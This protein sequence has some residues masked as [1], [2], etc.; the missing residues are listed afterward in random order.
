MRVRVQQFNNAQFFIS[1]ILQPDCVW[2]RCAYRTMWLRAPPPSWNASTIWTAR[3]STRS[4]GTR[5]AMSFIAMC[6][7]I[8][9]RR[10]HF[11]CQV[12]PLMWVCHWKK[13]EKKISK[14][15]GDGQ[16]PT[17]RYL[18]PWRL[19]WLY[20]KQSVQKCV[21]IRFD[22]SITQDVLKI[23]ELKFRSDFSR[24]IANRKKL[25]IILN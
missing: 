8:I 4:N 20:I 23:W 18:R 22:D 21:Y 14:S 9:R 17:G 13:S 16:K 25:S 10:K 19:S 3:R 15:C 24:F 5:M 7:G 2:S 11:V 6:P 1:Q 12:L